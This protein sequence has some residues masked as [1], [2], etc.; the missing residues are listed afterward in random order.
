M[1]KEEIIKQVRLRGKISTDGNFW[2]ENRR[3]PDSLGLNDIQLTLSKKGPK[4]YFVKFEPNSTGRDRVYEILGRS[5]NFEPNPLNAVFKTTDD[6]ITHFIENINVKIN[7]KSTGYE[8][9]CN[10]NN[11]TYYYAG[12]TQS[13]LPPFYEI[14]QNTFDPDVVPPHPEGYFDIWNKWV[15][16]T[17]TPKPQEKII[18]DPITFD[19]KIKG[20]FKF[21]VEKKDIFLIVGSSSVSGELKVITEPADWV[22]DNSGNPDDELDGEFIEAE[23][24]I[25]SELPT[26][27]IT[28]EGVD[29]SSLNDI[30]GFDPESP[31]DALS[32]DTN[33]KY[34]LSKDKDANARAIIKAAKSLG[35]TNGYTIAA[36]LAIV[37]KESG[38]VPQSEASYAKTSA[39]RIK[40]I[41]GGFKKYSE[42]EVDVIKKDPVKFFDIIYGG[43][44]GNASNEGY[45]YRGRGFNQITFKGNYKTY[46]DETGLNLVNDPDLLNTVDAAAKCV[47]AYFKRNVKK[48]PDTIKSKYNFT[49]INSFKNLN[50]AT[51]A[52]YHANAGWGK[53]YSEIVAD[54]TGGRKKSFDKAGPLYTTY[55]DS[56]V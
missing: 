56:L 49:D 5:F 38:F 18:Q 6:F 25:E 19:S 37:S 10:V 48:A 44:Y 29:I 40:K 35:V 13:G 41:F 54:S 24:N 12:L 9:P 2:K 34:P 11:F 55:K 3:K 43:K 28:T 33:S 50:D 22:F 32:T 26:T 39:A 14:V 51:G 30:K 23:T 7:L 53:S 16:E 45:K 15:E 52:I 8:N 46:A 42:S 17:K 21:N 1:A 47:I 4:N 27:L 20:D 36:I 31:N